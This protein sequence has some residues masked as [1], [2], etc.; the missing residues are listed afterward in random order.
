MKP[1]LMLDLLGLDQNVI[2][3]HLD[4]EPATINDFSI[5]LGNKSVV[6]YS[7]IGPRDKVLI[8]NPIFHW[9]YSRD[10]K[11]NENNEDELNTRYNI[12]VQEQ[13]G[14]N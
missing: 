14:V 10:V 6:K 11:M 5:R 8:L 2:N 1:S 13:R 9:K 4:I 12:A 3:D 7:T